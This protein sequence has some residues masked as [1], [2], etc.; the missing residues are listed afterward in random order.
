MMKVSLWCMG[1]YQIPPTPPTCPLLLRRL[2]GLLEAT[3]TECVVGHPCLILGKS[4]NLSK[5]PPWEL[6]Q[7]VMEWSLPR[8]VN[9]DPEE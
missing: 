1:T 6:M 9:R 4:L 8:S 5:L 3:P 2:L 7:N